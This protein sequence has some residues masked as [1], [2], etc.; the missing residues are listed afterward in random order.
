MSNV[1]DIRN[2]AVDP[3]DT[4]VFALAAE[5]DLDA[6]ETTAHMVSNLLYEGCVEIT[7][8]CCNLV[9]IRKKDIPNLIL[10]LQ[11]AQDLWS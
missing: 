3:I 2:W 6:V 4:I 5:R 9:T 8:D 7:A 1:I 10:A 11:K